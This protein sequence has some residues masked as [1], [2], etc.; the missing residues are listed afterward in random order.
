[1]AKALVAKWGEG[2][3]KGPHFGDEA[4]KKK[5]ELALEQMSTD[6]DNLPRT[7]AGCEYLPGKQLN[8][9]NKIFCS[10][11]CLWLTLAVCHWSQRA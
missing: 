2:K 11:Y 10:I 8:N 9:I 4:F 1:M 5:M 6:K 3:I 7:G